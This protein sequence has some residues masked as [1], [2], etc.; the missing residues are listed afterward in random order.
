LSINPLDGFRKE[1]LKEKSQFV[2]DRYD[3]EGYPLEKDLYYF[4]VASTKYAD[5]VSIDV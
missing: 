3:N 5:K 4:N 2:S 1:L